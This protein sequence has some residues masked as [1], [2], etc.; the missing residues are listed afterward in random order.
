MNVIRWG[1]LIYIMVCLAISVNLQA[2]KKHA[3]L[4]KQVQIT[5]TLISID[6]LSSLITAQTGVFLSYNS[7][8]VAE[9]KKIVTQKRLYTVAELLELIKSNTGSS[10]SIYEDHVIFHVAGAKTGFTKAIVQNQTKSASVATVKGSK[11]NTITAGIAKANAIRAN[12]TT[13]N[14]TTAT[15]TM[16]SIVTKSPDAIPPATPATARTETSNPAT[17]NTTISKL[18]LPKPTAPIYLE[19]LKPKAP[20]LLN[21]PSS[22]VQTPAFMAQRPPTFSKTT[23]WFAD[24]GFVVDDVLYLNAAITAGHQFLHGFF[25]WSSS[26]Q[27]SGFRYGLGS[28]IPLNDEWRIGLLVTTGKL[29]RDASFNGIRDTVK[30][31]TTKSDL[32]R[33]ALQAEK[34][35]SPHLIVKAGPVFNL[36]KSSYYF[37]GYPT[38]VAGTGYEGT[39]GDRVFYTV[40][41]FYTL[42]NSY[43]ATETTSTKTWIGF[44]VSLCYRFNF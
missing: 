43:K 9:R 12:N 3:S 21:P 6:S 8:K 5:N 14:T 31:I 28:M 4:Q 24:A 10:Y 7:N 39:D 11:A 27:T 22:L 23:R 32:H 2:Q 25:S 26:F 44:Q 42:S 29:S 1:A 36:L 17:P 34:S 16:T 13:G 18:T 20:Q 38:S 33:L 37:M 35:L 15:K 41:P 30:T 40:R 19:P